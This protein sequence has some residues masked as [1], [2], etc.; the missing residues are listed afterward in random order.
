MIGMQL[1]SI[2]Q[3]HRVNKQLTGK[4]LNMIHLINAA[5][6]DLIYMFVDSLN[7]GSRNFC[8]PGLIFLRKYGHDE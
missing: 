3:M 2:A 4:V 8:F 5:I 1:N 6:H 7:K